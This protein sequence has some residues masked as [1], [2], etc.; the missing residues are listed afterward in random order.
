MTDLFIHAADP[1]IA[2]SIDRALRHYGF[3]AVCRVGDA[4]PD[5]TQAADCLWIGEGAPDDVPESRIL[6]YPLRAGQTLDRVAAIVARQ[7]SDIEVP[8]GRL[9]LKTAQNLLSDQAGGVDIKVTDTEK[10]LLLALHSAGNKGALRETLLQ[11]VWGMR[12]D[13]DTHTVETHI[14]RLRQK[15]EADPAKPRILLTKDDGYIL[16]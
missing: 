15:I 16:V 9:V 10:R 11:Q 6:S 2:A 7:Q 12:P 1:L 8:V 14:Y 5:G 13:L 3:D 4:L